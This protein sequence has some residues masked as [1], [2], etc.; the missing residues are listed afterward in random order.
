MLR[1]GYSVPR[2]KMTRRGAAMPRNTW[3]GRNA[4]WRS[5]RVRCCGSR[6][7]TGNP[8]AVRGG[9]RMENALSADGPETGTCCRFKG[10]RR[11]VPGFSGSGAETADSSPDAAG[12]G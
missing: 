8:V 5:E 9:P 2:R 6:D 4:K 1:S 11:T 12:A 7:F 3:V 10:V